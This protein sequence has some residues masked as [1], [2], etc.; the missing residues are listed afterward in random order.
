MDMSLSAFPVGFKADPISNVFGAAHDLA[1]ITKRFAHTEADQNSNADRDSADTLDLMAPEL[2]Q[3]PEAIMQ[4]INA[5][6][7]NHEVEKAAR[8]M[9]KHQDKILEADPELQ[10]EF[11][12]LGNE[13]S[14]SL[15][16]I[17]TADANALSRDIQNTISEFAPATADNDRKTELELQREM[18]LE[19][20]RQLKMGA[21]SFAA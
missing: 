20:E 4:K 18:Q 1:P 6:L 17:P 11:A 13:I 9:L 19:L 3:S 21:P 14:Q 10:F 7:D 16:Y 8:I 15:Q 2:E 12:E 5:L